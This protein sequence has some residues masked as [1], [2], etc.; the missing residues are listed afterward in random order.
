MSLSTVA[1]FEAEAQRLM[2]EG[3]FHAMFGPVGGGKGASTHN[4]AAFQAMRLRP[5]VLRG[6]GVRSTTT[7]VLGCEVA[8]PVLLG[9]TGSQRRAH[10]DG[11]L[12][13]ARAA[14]AAGALMVVSMSSDFTLEQIAEA[15][16]GP[17]WFQ[18][19][20]LKDRGAVRELAGRAESA[21]YRA[22]VLTVDLVGSRTTE[23]EPMYASGF[24]D[25]DAYPNFAWLEPARRPTP[26]NFP[27]MV[28]QDLSWKDVEWLRSITSLP[29]VLKGIQT[30]EDAALACELDVGAIIVSN[31]GGHALAAARATIDAVP[32]VVEAVAGRVEVLMDGG[33]RCG[34]DVLK[35]AALGARAVLIGRSLYWGLAAGGA[36]GMSRVLGIIAGEL[37]SA[38][39]LCGLRSVAEAGPSLIER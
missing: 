11:E 1:D 16:G 32:E 12:A 31:H 9:P 37:D 8:L 10:P 13:A 18:V 24:D 19:Y 23:R 2:P 25:P 36:D 35:A 28:D 39:G 34:A 7:S 27:H 29:L 30:G 4:V 3:L 6:A 5:R 33:V 21:G 15:A 22:L 38:L 14:G 17:L 26:A 20:M